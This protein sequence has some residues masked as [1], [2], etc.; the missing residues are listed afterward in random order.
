VPGFLRVLSEL[1]V[2]LFVVDEA[3]CI[4]E[5]GH[6]FR[7]DYR[8]LS[9]LRERFPN[10]PIMALTATA[11]A[12]VQTD[13]VEQLRLRD[14]KVF[15]ASFDRANLTYQVWPKRGTMQQIV[16]YLNG[17]KGESG[18]IY[19]MSRKTTEDIASR[20]RADGFKAE[21]YHAG[22]EASQRTKVQENFDRDR[23]DIIV[24][25]V[26]FGMGIDKSNI[27]FVLHYHLPKS[28]PAYYQETGRA[29][30]DSLPS[31]CILFFGR[32]DRDLIVSLLSEKT[33]EEYD[34]SVAELDRM[35]SY[36]ESHEC[37]RTQ[38]L[39]YFG[40]DYGH[41]NCGACD[42]CLV[43]QS[44]TGDFDGT[45]VAQM[46]LSCLVRVKE[47]FGAT[48]VI[49]ILL[50]S[51]D[52]K[53]TDFRHHLLPTFGVGKDYS[54]AQ[55]NDFSDQMQRQHLIK[56]VPIE[57][58]GIR[59][60]TVLN[61]TER[62]W[63]VLRGERTVM[64]E[65]P[66]KKEVAAGAESLPERNRE[67]FEELRSLRRQIA[68]NRNV[69]PHVIFSDATLRL[70]AMQLPKDGA[71][72]K[73]ISGLNEW[74]AKEFGAE[75]LGAVRIFVSRH[76]ETTANSSYRPEPAGKKY[77]GGTADTTRRMFESGRSIQEIAAERGIS[78][79][80]IID[81]LSGFILSG[82]LQQVDRLVPAEKFGAIRA[83][84]AEIG[85]D[86]LTPVKDRL[87]PDYSWDEL[88]IARL[89]VQQQQSGVSAAV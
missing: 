70:I 5:W 10:V 20:L 57:T 49:R 35:V 43:E 55:W 42:N 60:V 37:R 59:R 56:A 87:G 63:E 8:N 7:A 85:Y 61:V 86:T 76:P 29:G 34:R 27:R 15:V 22:L 65:Q 38:L 54:K 23:T 77:V 33:G 84:F 71:A 80:T 21:A 82:E 48:H 88:R 13:I 73:S 17:K 69:S 26:A 40:E 39:R 16:G 44:A 64:F 52:K 75:F 46:F 25:T 36:A 67:L 18:I 58:S 2:S 1:N 3:H 24:A 9:V 14:P 28:I 19:C 41:D 79:N 30:R 31:D 6:D 32:S 45:R 51:G 66:K 89:L 62:G 53:L 78:V 68:E 72:L 50:G 4:S 12:R 74:K 83:A 11:N 81:H 47:R